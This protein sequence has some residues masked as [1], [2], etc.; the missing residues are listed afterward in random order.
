MN[1]PELLI[2]DVAPGAMPALVPE[3]AA[4]LHACVHDGASIGFILPFTRD[5][6]VRFWTGKVA[7]ALQSGARVLLVARSGGRL[8]G[9]VQLGIDT[10]PNQAHRADVSKLLVDPDF[11]RRGIATAL[12]RAIELQ[13]RA[14]D[15]SLLTLDT[16]TGDS[17]EPLYRSL[18]YQ[19]AGTIPGYAL[20]PAGLKCDP[21]TIMYKVC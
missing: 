6:A 12:M 14:L 21:T 13:A 19:T 4:L 11:R 9:S 1:R 7:P 18:G 16:R 17:A 20:D 10:M 3:L 2:D 8:A 15:R 5:D